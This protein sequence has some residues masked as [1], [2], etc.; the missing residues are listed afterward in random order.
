MPWNIDSDR[1][2]FIQLIEHMM[3]DIFAGRMVP[4]EQVKSVRDLAME[5]AVN[6]N[7]MQKALQELERMELMYSKRTSGRFV[8]EDIELIESLKKERAETKINSFLKDMEN[9]GISRKEIIE[10]LNTTE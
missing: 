9:I 5:A 7:T 6:P 10:I 8:T 2:V 1:P 3:D 4:G